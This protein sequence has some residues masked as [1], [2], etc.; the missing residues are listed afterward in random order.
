MVY[1]GLFSRIRVRFPFSIFQME[2][3]NYLQVAPT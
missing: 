3:L 2:V 1:H